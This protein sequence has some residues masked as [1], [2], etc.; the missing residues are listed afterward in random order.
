MNMWVIG[1]GPSVL[2][3]KDQINQLKGKNIFVYQNVFPSMLSYFDITPTYWTW[4]DPQASK[5]GV[6]YLAKNPLS[7]LT[8]LIPNI[9]LDYLKT[10]NIKDFAKYYQGGLPHPNTGIP[11]EAA[12]NRNEWY[13]YLENL[14]TIIDNNLCKTDIISTTTLPFLLKT[15]PLDEVKNI[16][17]PENRFNYK[18]IIY[19][20]D[21]YQNSWYMRENKLTFN[22][23]P[24]LNYLDVRKVFIIGFDGLWGR[25]YDKNWKT[26]GFVGEYKFLDR[27]VKWQSINGME[28]YSVTKCAINKHIPYL[29]FEEAL[30]IDNE[31]NN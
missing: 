18:D 27:W 3:Y 28:L 9:Y 12:N 17:K 2:K 26:K 6:E 7:S 1:P 15:K 21:L 4:G 20:T 31:T 8:T 29:P 5:K 13:L 16:M 23:L 24:I 10:Q 14:K 25:F 30:K 22:I 11:T 19:G